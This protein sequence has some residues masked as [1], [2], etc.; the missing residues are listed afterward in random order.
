M[1]KLKTRG[2]IKNLRTCGEMNNSRKN[3][4][5]AEELK[6]WG[7]IIRTDRNILPTPTFT[8]NVCPLWTSID[9][10]TEAHKGHKFSIRGRC[11][12]NFCQFASFSARS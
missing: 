8:E 4:K 10:S 9:Q 7:I 5:H 11:W 1:E 3:K 6:T 2:G 12:Q